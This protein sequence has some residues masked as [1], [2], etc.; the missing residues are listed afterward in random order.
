MKK[1]LL[2]LSL[3]FGLITTVQAQELEPNLLVGVRTGDGGMSEST[4]AT[5]VPG[6]W[7]Y[8]FTR[9]LDPALTERFK[10][11]TVTFRF[12]FSTAGNVLAEHK[13]TRKFHV[14]GTY[15]QFNILPDPGSTDP[16][17]FRWD[18]SGNF[19][20]A[21]SQL[22]AGQHPIDIKGYLIAGE[23]TLPIVVGSMTYDNSK[24]NGKMAEYATLIEKNKA[25]D[26]TAQNKAFDKKNPISK[27]VVLVPIKLF[28]NCASYRQVKHF[29]PVGDKIYGFASGQTKTLN[30]PDGNWLYRLENGKDWK[31]FGPTIGIKDKNKTFKICR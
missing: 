23:E 25:F 22:P 19:A 4:Q 31:S 20:K 30:V 24:G 10:D 6:N 7:L 17:S 11:Q 27:K 29:S 13:F 12:E 16:L 14:N 18:W 26:Q 15:L 8:A 9:K 3:C 28:N 1:A 21:L 2:I 5:F